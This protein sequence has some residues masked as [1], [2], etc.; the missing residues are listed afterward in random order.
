[1]KNKALQW[2]KE[3]EAAAAIAGS[4][5]NKFIETVLWLSYFLKK[6]IMYSVLH[7]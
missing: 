1:M 7:E 2:K 6:Q 3:A 4:S 5:D